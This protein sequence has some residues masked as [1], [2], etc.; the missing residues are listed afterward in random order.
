SV[1]V[2]HVGDLYAGTK[3]GIRRST[4]SGATWHTETTRPVTFRVATTAAGQVLA[5][6][7][8]GVQLSP[9]WEPLG[10][11]GRR[12]WAV[13]EVGPGHV[14]AATLTEGIFQYL[15][16]TWSPLPNGPPDWQAYCFLRSSTGR[17]LV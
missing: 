12:A 10:V 3:S 6:G 13:F 5:A 7:D 8:A 16:G 2:D 1:T 15:D 4:D 17:I 9:H 14:L 11:L